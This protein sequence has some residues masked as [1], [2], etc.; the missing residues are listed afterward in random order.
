MHMKADTEKNN[1]CMCH[2][3]DLHEILHLYFGSKFNKQVYFPIFR[4]QF[5]K[6]YLKC[7]VYSCECQLRQILQLVLK[8]T[9]LVKIGHHK[10]GLVVKSAPF[11]VKSAPF[12]CHSKSCQI[13][14][15]F[16]KSAPFFTIE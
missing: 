9:Y 7:S 4:Q 12:L 14:T 15:F 6:K 13:C 2:R 8:L 5:I 16:V 1:T 10:S 11:F 3:D